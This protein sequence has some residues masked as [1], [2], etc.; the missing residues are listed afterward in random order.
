MIVFIPKLDGGIRPIALVPLLL[1][2]WSRV[3]QP[4]CAQW[5]SAHNFHFF[6]GREGKGCEKAGW[7][8]NLLASAARHAGFEAGSLFLGIVKF[9]ENRRH[10]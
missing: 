6:W 7:M 2:V 5:E 9:Y 1:R 4:I 3:R 8:H 10:D